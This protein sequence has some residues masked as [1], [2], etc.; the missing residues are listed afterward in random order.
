ML[1]I[2]EKKNC[3]KATHRISLKLHVYYTSHVNSITKQLSQTCFASTAPDLNEVYLGINFQYISESQ[4]LGSSLKITTLRLYS[5]FITLRLGLIIENHAYRIQQKNPATC[6]LFL[7]NTG[8]LPWILYK[9]AN[10]L[11][12]HYLASKRKMKIKFE[13]DTIMF[14]LH[15]NRPKADNLS[16]KASLCKKK[17]PPQSHITDQPMTTRNLP[18]T[19][20]DQ[21]MTTRYMYQSMASRDQTIKTG[22]QLMTTRDQP[23]TPRNQPRHQKTNTWPTHDK[24][25]NNPW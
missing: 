13:N 4:E 20:R 23:M 11:L 15:V 14:F 17:I 3:A 22:D 19:I 25:E 16:N 5:S 7:T 8:S 9:H 21:P 18:M 6:I 12:A 10:I 1:L 24:N 2:Y